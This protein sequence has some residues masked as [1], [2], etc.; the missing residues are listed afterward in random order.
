MIKCSKPIRL[1]FAAN[2]ENF[3]SFDDTVATSDE[4]IDPVVLMN[5][6]LEKETEIDANASIISMLDKN[7][8]LYQAGRLQKFAK[9]IGSEK[10]EQL[11]EDAQKVLFK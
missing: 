7:E 5:E 3:S 8:A 2:I 6:L 1:L 11:L 4:N 9:K 10:A